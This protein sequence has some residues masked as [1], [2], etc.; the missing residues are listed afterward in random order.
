MFRAS[1]KFLEK[2]EAQSKS[3][4]TLP[5][6]QRSFLD[7]AKA[8]D[9]EKVAELLAKGVPVDVREDF[10]LHYPQNQETALMYAAAEGHLEMVRLLLKAGASVTAVD[11]NMSREDEGAQTPLHYAARQKNVAVIEELLG[12][13]ADVNALSTGRKTPLVA[14]LWRGNAEAVRLLAGRGTN[15]GSKIGRKQPYS[16]LYAAVDA[17]RNDVPPETAAELFTLLLEAGADP[18]GVADANMTTVFPLAS[19]EKWPEE[20]AA[21]ML[22]KLL[23]TGAKA[24]WADK[25]GNV[26][27]E[28]AVFR[29]KPKAVKLL[30]AA[31]AD[32]NR[33]ATRGTPLD[34]IQQD[35]ASCEKNLQQLSVSPPPAD[36][37]AA[38]RQKQL[39]AV[40]EGKLGRCREIGEILRSFGAR[41]KAA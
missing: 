27:L 35:T 7:A 31:G 2:L 21:Q 30:L 10:C 16:P 18:N 1:D 32:V 36:E 28:S 26:P 29:L 8:G 33:V 34:I 3:S 38:G 24:D 25:F 20:L 17:V 39:R 13:G 19:E 12:S 15:L 41:T 23:K 14:A 40:L 11:K 22:E 4:S 6:D 37:K 5:P 9:L